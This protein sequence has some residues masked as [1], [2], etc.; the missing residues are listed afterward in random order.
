[1]LGLIYDTLV[2]SSNKS[3]KQEQHQNSVITN[4]LQFDR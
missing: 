4:T 2:Y 1:M 3:H